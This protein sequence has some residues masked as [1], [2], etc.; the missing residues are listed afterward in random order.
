M[1]GA[2]AASIVAAMCSDR[3]LVT[4][5]P[6]MTAPD[7]KKPD[8]LTA[9]KAGPTNF[10]LL[11]GIFAVALALRIGVALR[12]PSIEWP[13]EIFNTLEPAH[14]L[15]LR[16]RRIAWGVARRHPVLDIPHS[17]RG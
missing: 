12:S 8:D 14:R 15:R 16:L 9:S 3:L 2:A 17:W 5:R 10:L 1:M 4:I 11:G 7:S 6:T 13:D